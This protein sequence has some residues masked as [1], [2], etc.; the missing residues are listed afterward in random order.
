MT[1]HEALPPTVSSSILSGNI[2]ILVGTLCVGA[3]V[4]V[5]L[6]HSTG[7]GQTSTEPW[8]SDFFFGGGGETHFPKVV[9]SNPSS[10]YWI[11]IF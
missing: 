9:G 8:S 5:T 3:G 6:L 4:W 11:D 7:G 10:I 2:R 1:I